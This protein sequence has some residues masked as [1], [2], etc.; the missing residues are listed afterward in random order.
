VKIGR[1]GPD[2][3]KCLS[4]ALT[5]FI[6]GIVTIMIGLILIIIFYILGSIILLI[7]HIVALNLGISARKYSKKAADLEPPNSSEKAGSVFAIFGIVINSILIVL[8]IIFTIVFFIL[9]II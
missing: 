9:I 4:Y 8:A 6:M 7:I 2:S 1:P 5:S 3:R